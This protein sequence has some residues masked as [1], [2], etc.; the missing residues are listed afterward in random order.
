[1]V[2]PDRSGLFGVWTAVEPSARASAASYLAGNRRRPRL[3][4]GIFSGTVRPGDV[5]TSAGMLYE[6]VVRQLLLA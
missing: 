2:V 1:M 5:I 3:C 6:W 4:N